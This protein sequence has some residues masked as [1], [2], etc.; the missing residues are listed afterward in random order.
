MT[1]EPTT[2]PE[3]IPANLPYEPPSAP[4]NLKADNILKM[5]ATLTWEPPENDGGS[6]VTGYYIEKRSGK[7]W[8]WV[9]VNKK[10]V[11]VCK[12]AVTDLIEKQEAEFR[13]IAENIGGQSKPSDSV[14][15]VAKDPFYIPCESGQPII[16][17]ITAE[18]AK[19][20][21][22]PPPQVRRHVTRSNLFMV[23]LF[24]S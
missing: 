12:L 24:V 17:E 6:P 11:K 21:W 23:N 8:Q 16:E 13:V 20:S 19:L 22:S 14:S 7:R 9:M 18:T 2:T 1:G 10:A 3:L 4:I 15:F 5:S